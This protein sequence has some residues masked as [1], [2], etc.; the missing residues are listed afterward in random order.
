MSQ[1]LSVNDLKWVEDI[2]ELNE[3]FIKNYNDESDEDIFLKQMF[4]IMKVY[5]IFTMILPFLP[6]RMKIEKH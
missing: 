1:K 2:F 3:D 6:E 5:I 4:S